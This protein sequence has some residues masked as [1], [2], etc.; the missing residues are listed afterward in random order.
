MEGNGSPAAII[1]HK[2]YARIGLLGNPSDVYYGRT[3]SLN[4]SNFW[5]SVRLEPSSDLVIVPHPT[6]DLV[7]FG[8]L[9]HLVLFDSLCIFYYYV[10]YFMIFD[11]F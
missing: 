11:L 4:I 1:E 8:S 3:I 10:F 6:H 7:K 5:A 2:A 9:S